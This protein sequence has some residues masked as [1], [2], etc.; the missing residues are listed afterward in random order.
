MKTKLTVIKG[1]DAKIKLENK[2]VKEAIRVCVDR[3]STG[4]VNSMLTKLKKMNATT[5]PKLGL[6][7]AKSPVKPA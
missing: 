6:V 5:K 3:D 1:G 7:V 4:N 2:L